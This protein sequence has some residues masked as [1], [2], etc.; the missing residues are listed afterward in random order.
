MSRLGIVVA[1]GLTLIGSTVG[2][3]TTAH[4]QAAPPNAPMP[5]LRSANEFLSPALRAEQ[6]DAF[7]NR[8]MLWVEQGERLFTQPSTSGGSSCASCHRDVDGMR[9]VAA[10]LP[11]VDVTTGQ[12]VNLEGRINVCRQQ[13]QSLPPLK[14]ESDELLALTAFLTHLSK[15][16][17]LSVAIDG[18]A[19]AF[20]DRGRTLWTERQ[21]QLN[22]ACSQC[23][24]RSVGR[25]L[26]G[27]T[28]SSAVPTGYPAYRLEWQT[29]GSLHR[30]L[31]A[32]QL[33]VRAELFEL[34][35]SE[36]L[37]LE[38]YLKARANQLPIDAP[39]LRR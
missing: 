28:I 16:E 30:R 2:L 14:Y 18:P 17:P 33:G 3:I 10:R 23:H 19:G 26:R 34:G 12:L 5:G 9:K 38:L 21:G 24:D 31:R 39:A 29:L 7:R 20:Y 4:G 35:S 15:G 37:A 27:D 36:Y 22:L 13:R 6:D 32:C 1:I 8:G 25:K 11:A